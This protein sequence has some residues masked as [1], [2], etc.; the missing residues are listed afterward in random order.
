MS[1][2]NQSFKNFLNIFHVVKPTLV[3]VEKMPL[4]L[5]LPYL[6]TISLQVRIKLRCAMKDTLNCCNVL[7][8][9]KLSFEVKGNSLYVDLKIVYLT[10]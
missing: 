9:V 6:R 8:A 3:T 2:I 5:I 7:I 4:L 1:F 10:S